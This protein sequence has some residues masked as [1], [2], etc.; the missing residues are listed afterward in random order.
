MFIISY[1]GYNLFFQLQKYSVPVH[2]NGVY[3][4]NFS[5]LFTDVFSLDEIPRFGKLL[6]FLD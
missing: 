4:N 2:L 6:V 3:R 1:H 5:L